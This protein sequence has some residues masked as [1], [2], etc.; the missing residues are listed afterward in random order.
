[1]DE[2]TDPAQDQETTQT[3]VAQ[4]AAV[5]LNRH[6]TNL[7][8]ARIFPALDYDLPIMLQHLRHMNLPTP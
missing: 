1:V 2:K 3:D 7:K 8:S 6:R 4:R 5:E